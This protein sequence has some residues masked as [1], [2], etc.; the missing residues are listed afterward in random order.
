WLT[1]CFCDEYTGTVHLDGIDRKTEAPRLFELGVAPGCNQPFRPFV[2]RT[3]MARIGSLRRNK[4]SRCAVG[5]RCGPPLAGCLLQFTRPRLGPYED[6][7][8]QCPG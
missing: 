7:R 4:I 3:E 2:D 6:G 1:A 5:F 8:T